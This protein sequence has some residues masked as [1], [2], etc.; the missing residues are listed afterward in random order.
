MTMANQNIIDLTN[1]RKKTQILTG[2]LSLPLRVGERAWI[3]YGN[4]TITT[5]L[6]RYIWEVA[7]DSILF[8]TCNTIY[9]LNYLSAAKTEVMC[10]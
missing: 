7:P 4:Q 6:V 1:A 9:R 8:E 5:S 3:T 2:T 10:A